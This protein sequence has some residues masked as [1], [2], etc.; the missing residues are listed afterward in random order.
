[1]AIAAGFSAF[2]H[3]YNGQVEMNADVSWWVVLIS[4]LV[5][6]FG[7]A[8]ILNNKYKHLLIVS[9]S[10]VISCAAYFFSNLLINDIFIS[11]MV[12]S[13]VATIIAEILAR[14]LRSPTTV[15]LI[16]AI[17]PFV[18]GAMLFYMM[19]NLINGNIDKFNQYFSNL[20][21]ASLGIAVGIILASVFA[22]VVIKTVRRF[23]TNK[24]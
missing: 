22:Q 18:P 16:P 20:G 2:A 11:V 7:F 8:I 19:Y 23:K 9:I 1:M 6:T 24:C 13:M 3:L 21:L 15:F 4:S 12:G 5:A 14:V 10:G 17:I